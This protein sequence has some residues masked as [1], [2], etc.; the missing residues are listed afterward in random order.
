MEYDKRPVVI[1]GGAAGLAACLTLE[2]AGYS[3]LL[4]EASD[5]L[6][7]RLRTDRLPDGTPVDRGFQ[8]LQTGYPE[9]QRW[10][11]FDALECADFV[12]GARVFLR[13][14][15]RTLADPRRSWR[16]LPATLTSGI[17]NWSDRWLVLRLVFKLQKC[18][19]PDIQNGHFNVSG[20]SVPPQGAL[21]SGPWAHRSTAEFL[22]EWG[23]SKAFVR[24]FLAPFFSGIFLEGALETPAAQFQYTFRML[25]DGKVVRPKGGM[26][27]FVPRVSEE[28]LKE[29]SYVENYS[30]ELKQ[31][32]AGPSA[33]EA[34]KRREQEI[35]GLKDALSILSGEEAV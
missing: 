14:K 11:D 13:N 33:E 26:E 24:D 34:K 4:I 1:G 15:W 22:N 7:G 3:P 27:C 32:C 29:L 19:T 20:K 8:V 18:P 28:K 6:G 21:G 10:V 17:G 2:Q 5:R 30:L 35:D 9:L 25:A 23:F 31:T 12:P 16:S